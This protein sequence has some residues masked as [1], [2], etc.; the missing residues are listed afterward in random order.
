LPP[1]PAAAFP[2]A[3]AKRRAVA[4]AQAGVD[5]ADAIYALRRGAALMISGH[6]PFYPRG[7]SMTKQN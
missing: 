1:R 5:F 2:A 6:A 7:G 4:S 3:E